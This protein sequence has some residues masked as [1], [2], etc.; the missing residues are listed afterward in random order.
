MAEPLVRDPGS[1]SPVS[2][3]TTAENTA[4]VPPRPSRLRVLL[5]LL[6]LTAGAFF[7]QGYHP[8]AEDA[9][10]YL[11]GIEKILQPEL[12]PFNARFFQSHAHLT[13]F[14]N[15]IAASVE[16]TRLPLDVVT[17]AWQLLSL[18]L[19]LLAAWELTGRCFES[20]KARWAAVALLAALFTLPVAGTALYIMDQYLNPRNLTA[21]A[22]IFAIAKVLDR[23]YVQAALFLVF[24]AALHPLM[25]AF[26][27]FFAVLLL[28]MR[29]RDTRS[30]NFAGLLPLAFLF[31][32]ASPAYDQVAQ[33]HA[34]HYF[35]RWQWYEI[36]GAVAPLA[37]FWGFSRIARSR[38]MRNLDLL[39]RTF[40]LYESICIVAAVILSSSPRFE[41][42]ARIQPMRSL[43][44]LY[45]VMILLGG[46]FAGEYL[47]KN[48]AWRWV[49]LFLPLCAGMFY[50]QRQLF[51]ASAHIEWPGVAPK[52]PWVQAFVWIRNNTPVDAV[53]ALDPVHMQISGE[54]SNGFRA[55][56]ERSML[57]D[58]A[59]DSGAVT[60][61][62]PL[63]EEWQRQVQAQQGWKNFQAQ[64]FSRLQ[65]AYGVNW[66]VL[67]QPG[68]GDLSCPY[69][70]QAVMVCRLD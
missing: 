30:M 43:Y 19:L 63:A 60:M 42:L 1:P 50:A 59:K 18:F 24:A 11:P 55:I 6:L 12:F 69:Q 41:A 8:G 5:V 7:V 48:R 35:L 22:G 2:S 32:G 28:G 54:D 58:A 17:F 4:A 9:E 31:Q 36:L 29:W 67:Q 65:T 38:Q 57:A 47:L 51:P 26:V 40:M 52:N 45:I 56:A 37:I 61:F 68:I 66:V 13:L 33:S 44:L 39:C 10:I 70:N 20:T 3:R 21:F 15:L 23:K 49:A 46:G 14:P 64:D 16:I 25:P 34:Y 27:I 53:F 62:P